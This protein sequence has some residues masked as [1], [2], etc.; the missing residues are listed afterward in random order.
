MKTSP[1][2]ISVCIPAYNTTSYLSELLDSIVE[3]DYNDYEIIVSDDNS[4]FSEEICKITKRFID[5]NPGV[6]IHYQKNE[7]N[8]GY[9]GNMK[10]LIRRAK[11]E[12][13]LFMGDDDL[14]C[15]KLREDYSFS[16]SLSDYQP[17]ELGDNWSEEEQD[18]LMLIHQTLMGE[19]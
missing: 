1:P 15:V 4:P 9:D 8:L 6:P 3:Q 13:C 2:K 7:E 17:V 5:T 16:K 14:M 10:T 18:T 11:G 12:Y 19:A